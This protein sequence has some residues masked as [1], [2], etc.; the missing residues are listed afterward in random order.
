MWDVNSPNEPVTVIQPPSPIIS[1]AF[2]SKS[3]D[4]LAGGLY[5]GQ[6][7]FW[8]LRADKAPQA[9]TPAAGD[10]RTK[11]TEAEKSH[12]DA[13]FDVV[14]ANS[15]S[16]AECISVSP[17][18]RMLWWDTRNLQ[19]PVPSALLTDG[20]AGDRVLGATR[21]DT[22]AEQSAKY[23]VGTEQGYVLQ[24]MRK[25]DSKVGEVCNRLGMEGGKHHGPIFA[26]QR[27]PA[28]S[29]YFLTVG[30]WTA[31]IWADD[32]KVPLITTRY[33]DAY[34]TDGCWSSTR[35]GIFFLT[36]M[37]GWIDIWDY[38]YRQNEVCYSQKISDF[39]LTCLAVKPKSSDLLIGD[40]SG[41][42]TLLQLCKSLWEP[43]AKGVEETALKSMFE[44]EYSREKT[45]VTQR[46]AAENKKEKPKDAKQVDKRKSVVDNRLTTLE[47]EFFQTVK[48]YQEKLELGDK[49]DRGDPTISVD[50]AKEEKDLKKGK[51]EEKKGAGEKKEEDEYKFDEGEKKEEQPPEPGKED[52][53]AP[54]PAPGEEKKEPEPTEPAKE[55]EP[56]KEH[57]PVPEPEPKK[58]PEHKKE[59]EAKPEEKKLPEPAKEP[60]PKKEP[61]PEPKKEPEPAKEPEPKKEAKKEPD[62]KP[63]KE[64][65]PKK[66]ATKE[67]EPK[68]AKEPEPKKEPEPE[69]AAAP[70]DAEP[71]EKDPDAKEIENLLADA[72]AEE[73]GDDPA[74]GADAGADAGAGAGATAGAE[75]GATAGAE[76]GATAGA[77]AD[78]VEP[79]K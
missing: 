54:E 7:S 53:Q 42:I 59:P 14:W 21:I 18:G 20:S 76:A 45:L 32:V 61:K 73:A 40:A 22:S 70:E 26:I 1:L 6:V 37:D 35:P 44:R 5:N 60:E 52:T 62:P 30:D 15:K 16:N 8:D 67:P 31:K 10:D 51:K 29:K 34:L 38:Y 12:Y 65:E 28:A 48:R 25:A 36:R 11:L 75:A 23:L 66:E 19:G 49:A 55:P 79:P 63:A 74:A 9:T 77:G 64:P 46:K 78:K 58:E 68:P 4:T 13:V 24:V 33:H 2:N 56:K 27:N 3:I 47:K 50:A 43:Q 17:D 57:E 39:P 69:P 71:E 72:A 41:S